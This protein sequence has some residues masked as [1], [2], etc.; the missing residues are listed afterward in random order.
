MRLVLD[1]STSSPPLCGLSDFAIGVALLFVRW[2]V[3]PPL[4]SATKSL[5][6]PLQPTNL[7]GLGLY[8]RRSRLPQAHFTAPHDDPS[9]FAE[10]LVSTVIVCPPPLDVICP[11]PLTLSGL[12]TSIRMV[13]L[14]LTSPI[15]QTIF[16]SAL[17]LVEAM[18]VCLHSFSLLKGCSASFSFVS[19]S[20]L[21]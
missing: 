7:L 15:S 20:R 3:T 19:Q 9:H 21:V 18:I 8:L 17:V 1:R 2:P 5:T 13:P 6:V 14:D 11:D 16:T 4:A 10:K 12:S